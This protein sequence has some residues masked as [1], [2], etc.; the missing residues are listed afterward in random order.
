V[1]FIHLRRSHWQHKTDQEKKLTKK[2]PLRNYPYET[3]GIIALFKFV[4]E[5]GLVTAPKNLLLFGF[6]SFRNSSNTEVPQ[7]LV[8]H[9]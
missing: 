4:G 9:M 3:V 5:M 2:N 1:L 7:A 8:A 6:S